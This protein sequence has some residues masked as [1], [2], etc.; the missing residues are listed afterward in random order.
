MNEINSSLNAQTFS[1]NQQKVFFNNDKRRNT[2]NRWTQ[3]EENRLINLVSII[4]A[5]EW[6]KISAILKTKT[7]KQCR[8]HYANCLNPEIKNSFWTIEEERVLLEKYQEYGSHWSKIKPFLPG[9]TSSMIKNYIS[10]LLK[11]NEIKE[12]QEMDESQNEEYDET[13]SSGTNLESDVED[14]NFFLNTN[15]THKKSGKFNYF[16]INSLLV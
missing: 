12:F 4:G 10:M 2:R 11:K 14:K 8:D 5:R 1:Q 7:A 9:R 3:D 15:D 13:A 6:N 16:D